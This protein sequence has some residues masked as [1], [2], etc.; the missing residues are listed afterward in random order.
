MRAVYTFLTLLLLSQAPVALA[1]TAYDCL[2]PATSGAFLLSDDCELSG[3]VTLSG[4]LDILGVVKGD[5]SYPVVKAASS[6]RHFTVTSG[7]HKL[8]LKY[9]KMIDG[10]LGTMG[11]GGSI[12]FYDKAIT[13]NISHCVFFNNHASQGGAI[14]GYHRQPKVFFDS[15]VFNDN[16]AYAQGGAVYLQEAELVDHS[17]T[18]TMNTAGDVGGALCLKDGSHSSL[19]DSSLVNNT[20]GLGGGIYIAGSREA[21]TSNQFPSEL[22]LQSVTLQSNTGKGLNRDIW[23]AY[24]RGGGLYLDKDVTVTIKESTFTENEATEGSAGNKQGHQ[25]MTQD[26]VSLTIVNTQFTHIAGGH[27][28]YGYDS[29]SS[30]GSAATYASPADCSANPCTDVAFPFCT[31]LGSNGVTCGPP[32]CTSPDSNGYSVTETDLAL[33]SFAVTATCA[34]SGTATVT[35]CASS[36]QPYVLSGCMPVYDCLNPATTGAFA[37]TNDCQLSGEVTLSGDLDILGVVKGDGSYPVV[38]AASS[39]RHFSVS[40]A[41]KLT[42]KYLKMVDGN[43]GTCSSCKGGSIYMNGGNGNISHCVFFNNSARSGGAIFDE[44]EE[45]NLDFDSVV[46]NANHADSGGAIYTGQTTLVGHFCTFTMNTARVGG[47]IYYIY[48]G[49]AY[50]SITLFDSTFEGNTAVKKG[51]G[52]NLW[53]Y[54]FSD[55]YYS[56]LTLTRVTMKENK[57]TGAG[58]D[59]TYGGGGL[60]LEY[61]ATAN[62]RESTFIDN[63]ATADSGSGKQGH[64]VFTG[65]GHY[66]TPSLTIVNTQFT[67]IAGGHAFYGYNDDT[68]SGSAATYISPADCSASPCTEAPFT[69]A[70]TCAVLGNEGVTCDYDATYLSTYD[71]GYKTKGTLLPLPPPV[72]PCSCAVTEFDTS[73]ACQR[74]KTSCPD[75]EF[76]GTDGTATSDHS[77]TPCEADEKSTGGAPCKKLLDCL[78]A[79]EQGHRNIDIGFASGDYTV[80]LS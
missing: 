46:F 17:S 64:Q 59:A 54:S 73:T 63:E 40:G 15:V 36:G 39:S 58:T 25:I 44:F 13:L 71:C 8:T 28:F 2:N 6:S 57:Q 61:Y 35:A 23:L 7:A 79:T 34:V 12:A 47:A 41:H 9:L 24:G 4:D 77:C 31:D 30:S 20:A 56:D 19:Y 51:G 43:V 53:G 14:W 29:A 55:S 78:T 18:Y 60:Y 11:N 5:G 10:N 52:I 26:A 21:S 42:L 27:A 67:N 68:S 72:I 75:G 33:A 65:K 50:G 16:H 22:H 3:E 45:S 38:K 37:L 62:I 1:R 70:G 80:S 48:M 74:Y 49:Y 66:G 32:A 69:A 76:L